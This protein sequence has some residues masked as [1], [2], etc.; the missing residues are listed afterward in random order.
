MQEF[1]YELKNWNLLNNHFYL[2]ISIPCFSSNILKIKDVLWNRHKKA[3]ENTFGFIK[4]KITI[5]IS[6]DFEN[7]SKESDEFLSQLKK[8]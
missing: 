3:N 2:D 7:L 8:I 4:D 1:N 6:S 5:V